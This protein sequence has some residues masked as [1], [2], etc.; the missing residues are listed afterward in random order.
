[1]AESKGQVMND[2]LI[3]GRHAENGLIKDEGKVVGGS[4]AAGTLGAIGASICCVGP[5]VLV[6]LGIGGAWVA[7]L[8]GL[9]PYRWIFLGAAAVAMVFAYRK[10]YRRTGVEASAPGTV[11]AIPQT[12]R[13]YKIL[14]WMVAALILLSGVSPYLAPLF[15]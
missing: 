4:L 3:Q 9:M 8:T 11:C 13:R 12:A 14:F 1:M 7:S 15:Y 10:I 6:S 5:L 2:S